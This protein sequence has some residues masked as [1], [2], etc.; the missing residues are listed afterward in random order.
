MATVVFF[1]LFTG[2]VSNYILQIMFGF[3]ISVV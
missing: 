1:L 2:V 3:Y